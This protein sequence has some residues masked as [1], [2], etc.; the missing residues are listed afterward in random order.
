MSLNL[1]LSP[2]KV[3]WG[4][5][6]VKLIF[7]S[8]FRIMTLD[9][10]T[11]VDQ[12]R[13]GLVAF[14]SLCCVTLVMSCVSTASA[15]DRPNIIVITA[16]DLGKQLST[17][18][19]PFWTPNID[20]FATRGVKF[21]KGYVTQAS[22]SSSRSSILTGKFPTTNGQIGLATTAPP[23]VS[24]QMFGQWD[25]IA[26]S[27]QSN[28]YYTGI[29]GKLHVYPENGFTFNYKKLNYEQTR[30]MNLT[31]KRVEEIIKNAD[32]R[33]Q[34]FFCYLNYADPHTPF[35]QTVKGLPKVPV[36]TDYIDYLLPEGLPFQGVRGNNYRASLYYNN[37]ARLDEGIGILQRKL[38]EK[39]VLDNTLIFFVGDHGAPFT[40]GKGACFES[41]VNVP[42]FVS[43]PGI[44]PFQTSDSLVSTIDIFPTICDAAGIPTPTSVE[45]KSLMPVLADPKAEVRDLVFTEF[46]M[47]IYR[48]DN[49]YPR[50]AVSD[51]RYKVIWNLAKQSP[52]NRDNYYEW[53]DGDPYHVKLF[54]AIEG[55]ATAAPYLTY[56]SYQWRTYFNFR[57]PSVVEVYD[58]QNDPYEHNDLSN[59]PAYAQIKNELFFQL[60][61]FVWSNGDRFQNPAEIELVYDLLG[62]PF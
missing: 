54:E 55:T 21:N 62:D 45:G 4:P 18:G 16:D 58:L 19:D 6:L 34:P 23:G 17:Y 26:Y 42:F 7:W 36:T 38:E 40:R 30:D 3:G 15:Q 47:H 51:G 12:C 14:V 56:D 32:N 61:Y 31:A 10:S 33:D 59:D 28:G 41:S 44:A 50:R 49:F 22:C 20:A 27:L 9:F 52:V 8:A 5:L 24:N 53:V 39:G 2:G 35:V 43:G 11:K 13:R 46:N 60:Q 25:N 37:L 29:I 57:I 1:P 48:W